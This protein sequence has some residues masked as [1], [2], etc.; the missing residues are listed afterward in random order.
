VIINAREEDKMQSNVDMVDKVNLELRGARAVVTVLGE[1]HLDR[2]SEEQLAELLGDVATVV[3][4]HIDA[5]HE[6]LRGW[7]QGKP[8]NGPRGGQGS[9]R[10]KKND[11]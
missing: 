9:D 8:W 4:G 2:F 7:A 5:A 1:A 3:E 11:V 6:A 10:G